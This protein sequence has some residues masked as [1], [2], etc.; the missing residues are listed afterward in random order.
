[1]SLSRDDILGAYDQVTETVDVPEWGD[2]VNVRSLTGRELDHYN[3]SIRKQV[4]NQMVV[5]PNVR[6][7]LLVLALVDDA[8]VRLFTDKDVDLVGRKNSK[9]I[10]RLWDVAARLSGLSEEA[11]EA[12]E[13]NS[14]S[15]ET[16]SS[17]SSSPEPSDAPAQ[18]Y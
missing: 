13:G 3:A 2:K 7:R 10:D 14:G 1:M 12:M 15:E 6:A 9:A 11:Q 8:G 4:G 16:D 5:Q 18:S 17:S